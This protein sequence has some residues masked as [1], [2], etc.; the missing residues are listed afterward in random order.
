MSP[1]NLFRI[2]VATAG[3]VIFCYGVLFL[4]DSLL[5]A[6]GLY[7]LQHSSPSY[8]A[9][10]GVLEMIIGVVIMRGIPPL[11]DLAFPPDESNPKP[12]DNSEK[13]NDESGGNP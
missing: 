10:R 7:Q 2:I 5:F 13:K 8:Y 4:L 11:A 9:T 1:R 6:V 3:L 12:S